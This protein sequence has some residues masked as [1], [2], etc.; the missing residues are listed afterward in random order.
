MARS[1]GAATRCAGWFRPRSRT[2]SCMLAGKCIVH[3]VALL[4]AVPAAFSTSFILARI[5]LPCRPL[6]AASRRLSGAPAQPRAF[7]HALPVDPSQQRQLLHILTCCIQI[8]D[9][10]HQH[11][12]CISS[13]VLLHSGGLP[14]APL[15]RAG[16]RG[17]AV[18]AADAAA[19]APE[20]RTYP[21][22]PQSVSMAEWGPKP[23]SRLCCFC[24][25]AAR[26][27]H[28]VPALCQRHRWVMA[29]CQCM[30]G[31]SWTSRGGCMA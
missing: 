29:T 28:A 13:M 22:A 1:L 2:N 16:W 18:A 8:R 4:Y 14:P 3:H 23:A 7:P 5:V 31:L 19:D 25:E 27:P 20:R 10:S 9:S 26:W 21:Y 30:I 12:G 15:R 6:P 17:Y 11:V 24:D